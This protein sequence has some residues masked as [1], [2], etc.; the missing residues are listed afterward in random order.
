MNKLLEQ[1]D[2]LTARMTA[3]NAEQAEMESQAAKNA[4]GL[5]TS[6]QLAKYESLNVEYDKAKA[7][8]AAAELQFNHQKSRQGRSASTNARP[9]TAPNNFNSN[10]DNNTQTHHTQPQ[11][12]G[13][14]YANMFASIEA[15]DPKGGF[16]DV[17]EYARAVLMGHAHDQRLAN[18]SMGEYSNPNGGF[19]VPPEFAA[20]MLDNSLENEIVRPRARIEPMIAK[21]K[22]I[23]RWDYYDH[24]TGMHFGG[25]KS[26]WVAECDTP[27]TLSQGRLE[28]M[29]L[30][31]SRLFIYGKISNQLLDDAPGLS[32][33]LDGAITAAIGFDLDSAFLRGTGVGMPKGILNDPAKITVPKESGQDPASILYDNLVKMFARMSDSCRERAYWLVNA[34]AIP[35]LLTLSI[36]IGVSGVHVPVMTRGPNGFE[37]LTR[38][39]IFTEKVPAIGTEGDISFVDFSQYAVGLRNDLRLDKSA[40]I[41]FATDETAFR[42][43]LRADGQGT[44]KSA[45]TPL[46]GDTQSWIVTLQTRS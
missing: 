6:A 4:G 40:H 36:E 17:N 14:R 28:Q 13:R 31:A 11:T 27:A 38:P 3:I 21:D 42:A 10:A 5:M 24:S 1:I 35:E 32:G 9:K 18:L 12:P 25:L 16:S 20:L 29:T 43:I 22:I 7:D 19:A 23:A 15:E 46:F 26:Q 37:I 41:G 39:V 45:I 8:K 44:W 33:S 2:A 30:V 34:T